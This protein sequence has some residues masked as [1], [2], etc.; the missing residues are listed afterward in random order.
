MKGDTLICRPT[1]ESANPMGRKLVL[2]DLDNL[3]GMRDLGPAEWR[4]LLRHLWIELGTAEDDQVIISMCR[5]TMAIAVPVLVG[6]PAQLLAR[7]GKDGAEI[8]IR[9]AVNIRHAAERFEVLVIAS[10]DH[11]FTQM[12]RQ[13]HMR[14]MYV[15][16]V[17]STRAGCAM[18]LR[19]AADRHS[20]LDPSRLWVTRDEGRLYT[21]AEAS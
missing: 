17:C 3:S 12:A 20:Q 6:V 1:G 18:T 19:R 16:Q 8:A 4:E 15:W 10:G 9:D 2:V 21:H 13:A 5:H 14:D 7:D 11:F